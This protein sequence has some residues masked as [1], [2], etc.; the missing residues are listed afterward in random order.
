MCTSCSSDVIVTYFISFSE[1]SLPFFPPVCDFD[2]VQLSE[3]SIPS[4]HPAAVFLISHGLSPGSCQ[5]G[6]TR[7][8]P[9][10][11]GAAG[12]RQA[13]EQPA[14]GTGRGVPTGSMPGCAR[15]SQPAPRLCCGLCSVCHPLWLGPH[16]A[17][18][19][20]PESCRAGCSSAEPRS[21][22]ASLLK[23]SC[24]FKSQACAGL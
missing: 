3:A 6:A 14:L 21:L 10:G 9:N 22:S 19:L 18:L 8:S 20:R 4:V 2:R 16:G 15:S 17:R 24:I 5:T 1:L 23:Q 13:S 11:A 7:A 12:W